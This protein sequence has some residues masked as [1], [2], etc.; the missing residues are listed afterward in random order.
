MIRCFRGRL[1]P[2][3]THTISRIQGATATDVGGPI[4][5]ALLQPDRKGP[6]R[7]TR[8]LTPGPVPNWQLQHWED[9]N[10]RTDVGLVHEPVL[11]AE[12]RVSDAVA[13][14]SSIR[15]VEIGKGNCH[16]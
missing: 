1:T 5:P 15:R 10:L 16:V 8:F 7:P 2:I 11:N 6:P 4:T 14:R 13:C 9:T 12:L 3:L